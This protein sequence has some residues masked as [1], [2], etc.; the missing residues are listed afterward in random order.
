MPNSTIQP[1][2][3]QLLLLESIPNEIEG[4]RQALEL[5]FDNAQK[6]RLAFPSQILSKKVSAPFFDFFF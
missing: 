6:C 4:L 3:S 1:A 5:V 2:L